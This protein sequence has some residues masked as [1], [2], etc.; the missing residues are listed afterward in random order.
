MWTAA[1]RCRSQEGG[2]A[3]RLRSWLGLLIFRA[4]LMCRNVV[5]I[6]YRR[7]SWSCVTIHWSAHLVTMLL[8]RKQPRHNDSSCQAGNGL[9][10]ARRSYIEPSRQP[11][12]MVTLGRSYQQTS[13]EPFI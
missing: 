2:E 8:T 11:T 6:I 3:R 10:A 1:S 4:Q 9:P 13:Q 5:Y 12:S 7:D